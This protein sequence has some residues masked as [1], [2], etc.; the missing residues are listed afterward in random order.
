MGLGWSWLRCP[1]FPIL[2][3]HGATSGSG[4]TPGTPSP[5]VLLL[6]HPPSCGCSQKEPPNPAETTGLY[7]PLLLS[8]ILMEI[9]FF[10]CHSTQNKT[11]TTRLGDLH[12]KPLEASPSPAGEG[13]FWGHWGIKSLLARG[14]GAG[15]GPAEPCP[16]LP[17][18]GHSPPLETFSAPSNGVFC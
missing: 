10:F 14:G 11:R 3:S 15:L 13:H 16:A 6:Q 12:P 2:L 4:D 5:A 7:F 8:R 17:D 18:L 9:Q 1:L